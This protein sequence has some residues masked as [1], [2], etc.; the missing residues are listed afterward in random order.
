MFS[1]SVSPIMPLGRDNY[2]STLEF[3]KGVSES[4]QAVCLSGD[5]YSSTSWRWFVYYLRWICSSSSAAH[6]CSPKAARSVERQGG[7]ERG[8]GS[9]PD[10]PTV[11]LY[12]AQM[13]DTVIHCASAGRWWTSECGKYHLYWHRCYRDDHFSAPLL[14]GCSADRQDKCDREMTCGKRS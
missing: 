12:P 10:S 13:Y 3:L 8:G 4:T 9:Y 11:E 7:R 1:P 6:Y 2:L 5:F 14:D